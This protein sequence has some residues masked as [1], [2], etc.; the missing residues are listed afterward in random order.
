VDL[1][2]EGVG[3]EALS[4]SGAGVGG[5]GA[6]VSTSAAPGTWAGTI[7]NQSFTVGGI[8][9]IF[10]SG[11]INGTNTLTKIGTGTLTLGGTTDNNGLSLQVNAGTVVLA[12]NSSHTPDVHA[13]GWNSPVF[14]MAISGGAPQLGGTGGAQIFDS[15][16]VTVAR[17]AFDTNGRN[18]TI[19]TLS[20]QGSGI[21][22]AGALLN[23]AAV[24]ST[25]TPTSG[26]VLTGDATIG[27]SQSGGSLTLNGGISGGF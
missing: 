23:S 7:T 16:T 10:I 11:S 9:D 17:G 15:A 24:G 19:A 2:G 22:G 13:V 5:L 8:G 1:A 12:K 14:G 4:I 27:V 20:L 25:I 21:G 6:L 26:V 3:A 18:E